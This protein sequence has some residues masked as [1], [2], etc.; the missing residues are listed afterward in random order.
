MCFTAVVLPLHELVVVAQAIVCLSANGQ[1]YFDN[2]NSIEYIAMVA[3]LYARKGNR[4]VH[5]HA[6]A[7]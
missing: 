1:G 2:G 6:V 3:A 4:F 7:I 5:Y